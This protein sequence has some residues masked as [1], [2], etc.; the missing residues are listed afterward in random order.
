MAG[1]QRERHGVHE[2][3]AF[4]DRGRL[5]KEM[6]LAEFEA[7]LDHVVDIEEFAGRELRAVY[8]RM[9]RGLAVTGCVFFLIEFDD[10]GRADRHWNLPLAH[11]LDRAGH[12]PDLGGGRIRL[13]C[14]SQCPI[15]WHQQSLWDPELDGEHNSFI[16]LL[17]AVRRNRLGLPP[18]EPGSPPPEL[19]PVA[20]T[21]PRPL[22]R[23][24]LEADFR[25][26]L[27]ALHRHYRKRLA[28]CLEQLTESRQQL[29][30]EQ[31]Q[32]R[33]LRA[34]LAHRAQTSTPATEEELQRQLRALREE[35]DRRQVEQAYREEELRS[36]RS[37]LEQQSRERAALLQHS[38]NQILQRLA[39]AGVTFVACQP[40]VEQMTV[41]LEE[42]A[43][44]LD[45]PMRY[46]A[47]RCQVSLEQYRQWRSHYEFPV[48]QAMD[49][50][51]SPCR[52]P[53]ARVSQPGQFIP[54]ADDRCDPHR[55]Q[56][57]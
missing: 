42:L 19:P 15:S 27:D 41:P 17:R 52:Q 12:G 5:V 26:R 25:E 45:A 16:Q 32:N 53:V 33:Q 8:L 21:R 3:V 48:C 40:G 11:L 28:Q 51:G 46:T 57:L 1:V 24:R 38:G 56:S 14:R 34:R 35:L 2:A 13:A 23:A 43:L 37:T 7:V 49:E 44:Y 55:H 30:M 10:Q 22:Q 31:S 20:E 29:A 39:R 9:N 54:G 50:E 47:G 36:L 4:F 6:L 18:G